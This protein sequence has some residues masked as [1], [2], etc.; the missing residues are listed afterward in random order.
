M[1][2][3]KQKRKFLKPVQTVI[4]TCLAASIPMLGLAVPEQ[5]N[6]RDQVNLVQVNQSTD[7]Q[8][9]LIQRAE[10]NFLKVDH[11]SHSSHSSHASHYSHYSSSS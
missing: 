3:N 11:Y 2:D 1:S 7:P 4:L 10:A 8:P 6:A 9:L 5:L